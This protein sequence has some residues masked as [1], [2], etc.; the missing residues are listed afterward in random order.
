[1]TLTTAELCKSLTKSRK[2]E[3]YEIP[4]DVYKAIETDWGTPTAG[5]VGYR[6]METPQIP[7]SPPR[8]GAEPLKYP[9]SAATIA[10]DFLKGGTE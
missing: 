4:W 3:L 6:L 9:I 5:L 2:G 1:M 8:S 7:P 10:L